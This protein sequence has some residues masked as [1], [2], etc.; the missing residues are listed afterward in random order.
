MKKIIKWLKYN[1]LYLSLGIVL[2][3]LIGSL[4]AS[5]VAGLAPCVLCWYQR[6]ALYPLAVILAV[7]IILKDHKVFHY[8]IA[9]P[10]FGAL[11]AFYHVLISSGVFPVVL[12]ACQV[13]VPCAQVSWSFGFITLPV[14]SLIAFLVIIALLFL[15]KKQNRSLFDLIR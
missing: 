12:E 8:A 3:G 9:F 1:A 2:L 14:L 13:G 10:I 4:Y 6:L 15:Y 7:G 11:V 5:E